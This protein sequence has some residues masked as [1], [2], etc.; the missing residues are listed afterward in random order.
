MKAEALLS[1]DSSFVE[2]AAWHMPSAIPIWARLMKT[3]R[4]SSGDEMVAWTPEEVTERFAYGIPSDC[5]FSGVAFQLDRTVTLKADRYGGK[6]IGT[7]GGGARTGVVDTFQ[8]KGIGRNPLVGECDQLWHSYGGQS[9]LD[10]VLEAINSVVYGFILPIGTIPCRAVIY[11]GSESAYL[12]TGD[13]GNERGP[14]ALLVRDLCVRPA[15]FIRAWYFQPLEEHKAKLLDDVQRTSEAISFMH[16]TAGGLDKMILMLGELLSACANQMSFARVFR[17][18][19]AVLSSSNLAMDGRWL[20]LTNIGF[21][22]SGSNCASDPSGIPFLNEL[23]CPLYVL[24]ELVRSHEECG[25]KALNRKPFESYYF[26]QLKAHGFNH[27]A[28]LLG[29]PDECVD[30]VSTT[31]SFIRLQRAVDREISTPC[32]VII[33]SAV[34]FGLPDSVAL[35]VEKLFI[36]VAD[37]MVLDSDLRDA[38]VEVL[39][40]G[41]RCTS[42]S[43][44]FNAFVTGAAVDALRK[45]HFCWI[46]T[47]SR[48]VPRLTD[49]VRSKDPMFFGQY[50]NR[51]EAAAKWIFSRGGGKVDIFKGEIIQIY[52]HLNSEKYFTIDCVGAARATDSVDDV[53]TFVR[54]QRHDAFLFDNFD[55]KPNLLRLLGVLKAMCV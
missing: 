30:R 33:G 9:L 2:F 17:I 35:L 52:Y 27:I 34:D 24:D 32:D 16:T 47:R 29:L 51:H 4:L 37:P 46:F 43:V 44:S 53:V 26:E 10:A 54:A 31:K 39:H 14:G 23:L 48:L 45:S 21:I 8:V 12:P 55:F 3:A 1:H 11:T 38:F 6:G 50:I 41:Y 15:H 25:G 13:W 5:C 36:S 28:R 22:P 20:D 7:N 18:Q 19:H 42:T 40:A 49:L